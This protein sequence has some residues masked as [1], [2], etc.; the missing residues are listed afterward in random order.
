[1]FNYLPYEGESLKVCS[2]ECERNCS[3]VCCNGATLI[4]IEELKSFYDV[5]PI[6][7]GFRKYTPIDREHKI[8]LQN[9]GGELDDY[10]IVGDFIAG[11]RF[12]RECL[13]LDNDNLCRLQKEGRKPL[14][15]KIVPFCAI[16]PESAQDLIFKQQKTSKFANCK[17]YRDSTEIDKVVWKDG[18]FT[19]YYLKDAFFNFQQG[20]AKQSPFMKEIL[21]HIYK[22]DFFKDFMEGE[23]VLEMPIPLPL[24]FDILE[25]AGFSDEEMLQF[26]ISQVKLCL[27]ELTEGNAENTVIEDWYNELIEFVKEYNNFVDKSKKNV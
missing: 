25:E 7:I 19:D 12:R 3:E 23:G 20:L 2:F 10:F 1:M 21:L 4:T 6:Y 15:C 5:F 27:R 26:I 24:L 8:F 13:G 9:I 16:Y 18:V 11:N 22:E 14:Q 17:G